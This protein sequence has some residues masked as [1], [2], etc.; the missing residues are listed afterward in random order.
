MGPNMGVATDRHKRRAVNAALPRMCAGRDRPDRADPAGLQPS[1]RQCTQRPPRRRGGVGA[2][3]SR[4]AKSPSSSG[5]ARQYSAT[6]PTAT[7]IWAR[8]SS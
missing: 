6:A 1:A 2:A 5:C 4:R 3:S 8:H 7:G